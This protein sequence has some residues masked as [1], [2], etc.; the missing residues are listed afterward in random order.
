V[1]GTRY[2]DD[3]LFATTYTPHDDADYA[4]AVERLKH[5]AGHCHHENLIVE[6]DDDL[7]NIKMLE[8]IL[9]VQRDVLNNVTAS[10][11][12][13]NKNAL[14][15]TGKQVFLKF[16]HF[17]SYSPL[18]AKRGVMIS[19]LIRMQSA[20]SSPDLFLKTI[21]SVFL[22]WKLLKYPLSCVKQA[23]KCMISRI[24]PD[25]HPAGWDRNFWESVKVTACDGWKE[26]SRE[27]FQF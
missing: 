25:D 1:L 27:F 24:T 20:C 11:Q 5:V 22:E 6:L 16:Q 7:T 4:A 21:P 14:M 12:H 2:V 26:N 17:E 8:S 19:T 9:H 3:A 15:E 23:I 13:K 18:S 10:F